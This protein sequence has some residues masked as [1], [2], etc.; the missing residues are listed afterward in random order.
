[1]AKG[2]VFTEGQEAII[3]RIVSTSVK[4]ARK[5]FKEELKDAVVAGVN[6][7]RLNCEAKEALAKLGTTVAAKVAEVHGSKQ[8]LYK[9]CSLLAFL[10]SAVLLAIQTFKH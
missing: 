3:E 8:T 9:I 5:E 6:E 10:I 1:M 7:H 2:V 4:E